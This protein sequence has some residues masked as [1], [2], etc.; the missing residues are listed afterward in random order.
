MTFILKYLF[1]FL[2]LFSSVFAQAD[3]VWVIE[4]NGGIGPATSDYLTREIEQAHD[5]QAKLIILKMNTPGGLDSSMRDIIRSIT[6]SP[7][8][9]ATWVGPAGSRAASAGTYILLASHIASMAPGTNLGAATPVSL[10][11]GKAPANPLSPQ[12]DANKD[13]H[14]STREKDETKQDGYFK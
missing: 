13:D 7:I 8:P 3:D 6:T 4:V 5:E 1:V 9:I 11:G 12:D 2:L 10:G 14:T